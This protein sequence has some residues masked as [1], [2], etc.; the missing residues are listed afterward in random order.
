MEFD[1]PA[2]AQTFRPGMASSAS[3]LLVLAALLIVAVY[4][5]MK[6]RRIP[7][8]LTLS[9]M[10][11]GLLIGYLHGTTAFWSSLGG[12]AIGFG[13]LFL[14]Y[15]FGGIGGGDVKLMGAAGALLGVELVKPALFYT[16]AIGA[17]MAII[18]II[19]R[20][21]FWA[22]CAKGMRD[23]VTWKKKSGDTAAKAEPLTVPYGV[24]IAAGCVM[25]L[26]VNALR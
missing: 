4:V 1:A 25:A 13:F 22:C 5:E 24:A 3:A 12:L 17:L 19:W 2:S 6:E 8:W 20:K 18:I 16:A 10:G 26:V 23:L 7:N 9:G 21:D 14:F 15:V 11:L